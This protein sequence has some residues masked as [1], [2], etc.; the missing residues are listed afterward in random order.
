MPG[1]FFHMAQIYL[2]LLEEQ[3]TEKPIYRFETTRVD[4]GS[5]IDLCLH[6]IERISHR[7]MFI[8]NMENT[9]PIKTSGFYDN[10]YKRF[11]FCRD[12]FNREKR[13]FVF[14]M[15]EECYN[16]FNKNGPYDL[17]SQGFIEYLK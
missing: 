2:R 11:N 10:G 8:F 3:L 7:P 17:L 15:T 4:E 6:G 13:I 16:E 1:E 5:Q 9:L 14:F 12:M